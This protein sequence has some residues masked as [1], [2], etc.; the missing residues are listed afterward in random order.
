MDIVVQLITAFTGSMGFAMMFRVDRKKL[1]LSSI[2]GLLS[3]SVYLLMGH[4]ILDDAIR[5]LI[6]SS[7]ISIYAEILARVI[8]TPA[9]IFIVT[10]AVPLFP[11]GSV[12]YTMRAAV[13]QNGPLFIEKAKYTLLLAGAI[14]L[15][16]ICT[17]SILQAIYKLY[18]DVKSK[19]IV[20]R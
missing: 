5:Y 12:Y 10:A 16:I 14:A 20:K 11:G 6:A 17:M 3:W 8:K 2:G 7:V 1:L 4:W 15:G 19:A 9:T 13:E 18:D